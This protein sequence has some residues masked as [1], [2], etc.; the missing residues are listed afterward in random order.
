MAVSE[1]AYAV[2]GLAKSPTGP[3]SPMPEGLV[4]LRFPGSLAGA[5]NIQEAGTSSLIRAVQNAPMV[6]I[7]FVPEGNRL[8]ATA[9]VQCRTAQDAEDMASQLTSDTKRARSWIEREHETPSPGNFSGILTSGE[10]HRE[11]TRMLGHWPI[12]RAFIQYLLGTQ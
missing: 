12:E 6:T 8:A 1:D 7:A 4:W 10:F 2:N 11:G 3:Y 5:W 9:D